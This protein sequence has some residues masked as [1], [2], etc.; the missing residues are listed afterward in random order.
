MK[1][2]VVLNAKGGSGKTTIATNLASYLALV[3][4]RPVLLDLDPQASSSRWLTR[5]PAEHNPIHGVIGY[6]RASS[7]TRSWQMRMPTTCGAVVVDTPAGVQRQNLPEITRGADAILVPVMPSEIDIHA[8]A[9]CIADLLLVANIRRAE[10]RIGIVANRVRANTR[11]SRSLMRFLKTLDLPLVATLRDTLNYVAAAE[12][13]LGIF[14][15]PHSRVRQD[16]DCWK[17]LLAWLDDHSRDV[18]R[19]MTPPLSSAIAS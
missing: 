12:Q 17:S 19:P 9:N 10:N 8:T 11:V 2:I 4:K 14:E 1:R 3:N 6:R 5:R 7:V 15:M 16:I 13:G 18:Y